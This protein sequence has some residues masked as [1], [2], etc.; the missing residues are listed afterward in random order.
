MEQNPQKRWGKHYDTSA[1]GNIE[2][3][4]F[5]GRGGTWKFGFLLK[6]FPVKKYDDDDEDDEEE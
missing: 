5:V 3:V 1:P 2:C 6:P 4:F